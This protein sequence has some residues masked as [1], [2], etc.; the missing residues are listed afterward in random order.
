MKIDPYTISVLE[1]FAS[2]NPAVWINE[3]NILET[4][5]PS[6]SIIAHAA[7]ETTFPKSFGLYRVAQLINVLSMYSDADVTFEDT[8]LTVSSGMRTTKLSYGDPKLCEP[9]Q[10]P[11]TYKFPTS[12]NIRASISA[13]VL[14]DL[15]KAA[16]FLAVEDYTI[17][18]D[19]ERLLAVATSSSKPG[20]NFHTVQLGHTEHTF[21]AVMKHSNVLL[22][23]EDYE[24][25][26]V[27][28]DAPSIVFTSSR[29]KYVV[30]LDDSS[31]F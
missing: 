14:K 1:N 12:S 19:G 25:D 2:I 27:A 31:E 10:I 26:V 24:V 6:K 8:H 18:G 9:C 11:A 3:G 21:K 13:V 5:S 23:P 22:L 29:V 4:V 28:G 30:A 7:V 17:Q 16:R 20:S 15:S